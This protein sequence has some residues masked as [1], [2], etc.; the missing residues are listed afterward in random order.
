VYEAELGGLAELVVNGQIDHASDLLMEAIHRALRSA[1]D[2]SACAVR[3]RHAAAFT[4][5]R[6]ARETVAAWGAVLE[7]TGVRSSRP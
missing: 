3:V 5:E 4:W 7:R 1:L 2:P 6:N